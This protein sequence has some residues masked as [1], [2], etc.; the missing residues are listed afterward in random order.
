MRQLKRQI[1]NKMEG[2][3]WR[4]QIID[5]YPNV[6]GNWSGICGESGRQEKKTANSED[7]FDNDV[8]VNDLADFD[9]NGNE[10]PF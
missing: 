4:S 1:P 7:G 9:E 10:T 2:S 3:R 6:H 8:D 5:S